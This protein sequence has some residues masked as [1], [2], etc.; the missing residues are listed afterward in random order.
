MKAV[1]ITGGGWVQEH[2]KSFEGFIRKWSILNLRLSVSTSILDTYR[3]CFSILPVFRFI[4]I[5]A[6]Y[7]C[8]ISV[9]QCANGKVYFWGGSTRGK[10]L[11]HFTLNTLCITFRLC[12]Q[13]ILL[14]AVFLQKAGLQFVF[15]RINLVSICCLVPETFKKMQQNNYN[16]LRFLISRYL[17][18]DGFLTLKRNDSECIEPVEV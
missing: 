13:Y 8:N 17:L 10:L 11:S 4:D 18:I 15:T 9:A 16:F 12:T 7:L 2:I 6:S 5:G 1:T 3:F 14:L